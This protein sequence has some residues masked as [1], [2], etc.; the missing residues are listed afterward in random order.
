VVGQGYSV[1]INVT[2]ENQGDYT[3]T[4]G[5]VA[6]YFDG[7]VIPTSVQWETF[8]SMGDINRDGYINEIDSGLMEAAYGTSFGDP[9]YN[10][11]ADL[12]QDGDVDF[13]DFIS[14]AGN[15]G[16]DIWTYFGLPLPPIGT[17]RAVKLFPGNQTTLTFTWNTTGF[18]KG[19]YIIS[20]YATPVPSETDTMDN[21]LTDGIIT[22]T[23]PGDINGD[24]YVGSFDF[25]VL[26]GAYASSSGDPAYDPEADI[27]CDGYIGSADF[28]I[29]AGNYGKSI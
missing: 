1:S 29:L 6:P 28:S 23:I 25:S 7:V 19:N 15:Y 14:L 10:P 20:A 21:T 24:G 18:A 27:D 13:D 8:W 4:F 16:L 12:D 5:V 3:E 26:A 11:D 9:N 17:Q 22:V 2:V